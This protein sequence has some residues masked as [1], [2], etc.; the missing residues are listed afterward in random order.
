MLSIII[1]TMGENGELRDCIASAAE[2]VHLP[3][4]VILVNNS[5]SRLSPEL[6]AAARLEIGHNAG[7]AR[8]VN[9]GIEAAKG[10]RLL[11]LNPDAR[12]TSDIISEMSSFMDAHERAGIVA[13]QLVFPD[14]TLQNSIDIIPNLATEFVNKSLLKLLFPGSYPSKR[15]GFDRPVRVPSVIGACMMIRREVIDAVGPLDEGYFLYLEETDFC[16]RVSSAGFEIWHLP[17][18]RVVHHQG[19]S[20]RKFDTRRKIEYQRSMRRFFLKNRGACQA[21]ILS[22]LTLVKLVIETAGHAAAAVTSKGGRG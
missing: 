21:L 4:E 1:V 13:P 20:A 9:R 19:T 17:H 8:A 6:S 11:L 15:T 16:R 2:H 18:L 12:F 7:F 22:A 10:D 14:G 3:H 5:P